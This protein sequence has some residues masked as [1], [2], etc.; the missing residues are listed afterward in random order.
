[1]VPVTIWTS[2]AFVIRAGVP[3]IYRD[4]IEQAGAFV[5]STGSQATFIGLNTT[6]TDYGLRVGASY[7]TTNGWTGHLDEIAASLTQAFYSG[8]YTP[9]ATPFANLPAV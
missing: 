9:E 4:G 1:V 7:L 8:N 3:H 5:S 6:R 2:L